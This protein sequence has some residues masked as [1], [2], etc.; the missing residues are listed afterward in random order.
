M[1]L[2]KNIHIPAL[3]LL[4][5]KKCGVF[6]RLCLEWSQIDRLAIWP[7]NISVVLNMVAMLM[8]LMTKEIII[9]LMRDKKRQF[10]SGLIV[11]YSS[12][13]NSLML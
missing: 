7:Y 13:F 2:E 11:A 4:H 12:T 9:R 3:Y 5:N 6:K 1:G 10:N 8:I